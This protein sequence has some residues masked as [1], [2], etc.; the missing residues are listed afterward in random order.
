MSEFLKRTISGLLFVIVL[1]GA[2]Y[3][4][5]ITFFILFLAIT[6]ATMLEFYHLGL[7]AKLRPQ[8]LLGVFIGMAFFI[9]SY[10]YSSGRIEQLTLYGFV[11]L[12]VS[13]F[14]VE[15][16]RHQQKPMQ[17]IALTLLG[18][19]YIA[20]PFSLMNFITING[21]SYSM[22][23]N[24]NILL[25]ILFLVWANDTGAYIVGVSMGK[26]KM[27]PR[28]SP[29][30]SWEG[31]VGGIATT[32]LVAWVIAMFFDEV[33]LKHWLAIGLITTFMAVLGDLVESM[34]KRSIG[35]KDSGKF[36]PGHGGLL[37]RFDALLMV[38][39][40]VYVYLEV[41]MII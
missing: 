29:K 9:W 17:N 12:L 7:K 34:F 6:T 15:L 3:I 13:I 37:D 10:F 26:H 28:I 18:I 38:L 27:I 14:V 39:P 31:F 19:F 21:S 1:V 41:M 32:L 23:Y 11:P 24:P 35:V 25:G 30:K 8:S 33:S 40:M 16:Y 4:G 22:D 5:H 36:L 2:I 20:L